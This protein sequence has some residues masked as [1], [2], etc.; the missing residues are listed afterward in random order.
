MSALAVGYIFQA[1]LKP[2]GAL[3]GILGAITGAE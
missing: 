1:L 3:N 2:D